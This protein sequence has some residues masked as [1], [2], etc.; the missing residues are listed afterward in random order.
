MPRSKTAL[1]I[2]AAGRGTRLGSEIPKQYLKLAGKPVLRHALDR[3]LAHDAIG[4][5]R[6]VID[7][8]HRTLYEEAVS[9]LDLPLPVPGGAERGQSVL[10]G[11]RALAEDAPDQVLVHDA[12]RPFVSPQV[13]DRVLDAI[14][15]VPGAIPALPVTDTLKRAGGLGGEITGTEDRRTLFRAQTPQGF[16]FKTLLE[17]HEKTQKLATDDAA[18]LEELGLAVRLVQGEEQLFKITTED[19]LIRAKQ[20]IEGAF[21]P[22]VGTG[23]DVHRLGPGEKI[24]LC[25]L[26]I[27][28]D[29]T[30][31]GHSDADVGLHAITDALL[32][33]IADGD[34][35][36]HFPPSDP[37]WKGAA[38]DQF[39]VHAADLVRQRGGRISH[40][41]VT[42]ICERPKIGPHRPAMRKRIAEI[43]E[44]AEGR[45]SVKAT[46]SEKLGFTGRGE[47]IAAQ[48]A[49]T[50]LL[51]ADDL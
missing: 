21:E 14:E 30:L 43:L 49:A 42:L 18:L 5:V 26:E 25:G 39:L 29:R 34:I 2:V 22:R 3:F 32:G 31:I 23:F 44:I 24:T 16:H 27:A 10:N 33:A 6:I 17:A 50:V 19:D 45:V 48:A 13:I 36:S 20:I 8:D 40:V 28:H 37:Q 46:T 51:P 4:P 1:L 35:G 38:S 41:D 15:D 11:L 47:G 7:P 9:G 12:A